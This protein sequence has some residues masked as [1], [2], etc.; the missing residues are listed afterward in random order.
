ME[1]PMGNKL[2]ELQRQQE[3][4]DSMSRIKSFLIA[5]IIVFIG[6]QTLFVVYSINSGYETKVFSVR[7]TQTDS[8]KMSHLYRQGDEVLEFSLTKEETV[9]V[10]THSRTGWVDLSVFQGTEAVEEEVPIEHYEQLKSQT[11]ELSL[12]PGDYRIG[13]HFHQHNGSVKVIYP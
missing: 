11:V 2:T 1:S 4:K 12:P 6:L 7:N 8:V 10:E 5:A 3:D 13:V 9:V